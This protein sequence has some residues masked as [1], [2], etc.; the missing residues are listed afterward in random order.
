MIIMR[1][2]FSDDN[3]F[4]EAIT[5]VIAT[6][7]AIVIGVLIYYKLSGSIMSG[8][9]TT[10]AVRAL[11]NNTNTTASTVWTLMP[12]IAVVMVAGIILA[13]VTNFGR[14]SA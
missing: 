6:L 5:A 10:V 4:V 14:G 7:V 13:I 8:T 11:Y 3:A 9:G 1:K 2:F 12:I